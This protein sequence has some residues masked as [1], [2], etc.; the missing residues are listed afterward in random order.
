[1]T[2]E[3]EGSLKAG[4]LRAFMDGDFSG[5]VLVD[6]E[7]LITDLNDRA[8]SWLDCRH[9]DVAG[10][11]FCDLFP[12]LEEELLN[13]VTRQGDSVANCY[14]QNRVARFSVNME[15]IGER[16]DPDGA[17]IFLQKLPIP[18][19]ASGGKQE[20]S[21]TA[22]RFFSEFETASGTFLR[23]IK[24]LKYTAQ[25]DHPILLVGED[26]TEIPAL[27]KC[28][29]NESGRRKNGYAEVECDAL[30]A[31]QVSRLLFDRAPDTESSGLNRSMASL[32][33]GTLFLSH[34]DRLSSD[35]QYRIGLLIRGVYVAENDLSHQPAD[36]RVIASTDRDLKELVRQG[37]FREDLYYS[38]S[39]TTVTVPPLRERGDEVIDIAIHF[40]GV[41]QEKYA[42]PVKL[43]RGAYDCLREYS[44][45]G[46]TRELDAFCRKIVLTT[47]RHS[48]NEAFIRSALEENRR[49]TGP[50]E[51]AAPG[52]DGRDD[53]AARIREALRR[54]GGSKTKTAAELGVSKATLWRH[55][56]KYGI[57]DDA[58]EK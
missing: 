6:R 58:G 24:L 7:G 8:R 29:H 50:Q 56:Q 15:P 16:D 38:L 54:N 13:D 31:E 10:V 57:R 52:S 44:W 51:G 49:T 21:V 42:K 25:Q 48:V 30:S 9:R 34:I 53:P 14:V 47:P 40:I 39:P 3:T 17:V 12:M 35:L 19:R 5:V 45:P 32:Q 37:L 26:G 2:R 28:I 46:N 23:A 33:G 11:H 41:Y 20:Y 55:M 43:T 36:V 27:A 22:D 4:I 1:M 18:A